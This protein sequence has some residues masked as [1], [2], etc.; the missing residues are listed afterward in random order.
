MLHRSQAESTC[1]SDSDPSV[2]HPHQRLA[3]LEPNCSDSFM[4][5]RHTTIPPSI[6]DG[7][8]HKTLRLYAVN[9]T[10]CACGTRSPFIKSMRLVPRQPTLPHQTHILRSQR[11]LF[12]LA[13]CL[14]LRLRIVSQRPPFFRYALRYICP[15]SRT[16][17][18]RVNAY[19]HNP[20]GSPCL[21]VMVQFCT[22]H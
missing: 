6:H 2:R 22:Y 18:I 15:N 5:Q 3:R 17:P 9:G 12:Y 11:L 4:R 7:Y 16:P 8:I 19:L 21:F 1:E 13:L 20:L 10:T 14:T